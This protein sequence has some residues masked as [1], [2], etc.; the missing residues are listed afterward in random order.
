MKKHI[1]QLLIIAAFFTMLFLSSATKEG[2]LNGLNLWLFTVVPTLLPFMIISSVIVETESYRIITRI[3][4]YIMKPVFQLPSEAAYPFLMGILCGF[5]MGSKITA[6]MVKSGKL[7]VNDGNVLLT[8]CNNISPPFI[9]S[10]MTGYVLG[11]NYNTGK[12]VIFIMLISPIITGIITSR[13]IPVISTAYISASRVSHIIPY[14]GTTDNVNSSADT[15]SNTSVFSIDRCILSGVQNI[16]K[17]GGYI[18]IFSIICS[19]TRLILK[20]GYI[21]AAISGILEITTGLGAFSL[22][23]LS[24]KKLYTVCILSSFGGICTI[25]QTLCMIRGS[26]LSIKLYIAGKLINCIVTFI[27]LCLIIHI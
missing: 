24:L 18:I 20:D 11:L 17:L 22:I 21:Y 25:A 9:I 8:F 7:S 23:S 1:L 14:T 19:L 3:L 26:H 2:A 10:Y 4:G 15:P 13:L 6:D 12:S 5:P 16:I 27:L